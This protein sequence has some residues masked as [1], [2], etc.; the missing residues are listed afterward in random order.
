MSDMES[1]CEDEWGGSLID[2]SGCDASPSHSPITQTPSTC[3][4]ASDRSS[5]L[6]HMDT[7]PLAHVHAA[8]E[9][10]FQLQR[11]VERLEKLVAQLSAS[12]YFDDDDVTSVTRELEVVRDKLE[13]VRASVRHLDGVFMLV[14]LKHREAALESAVQ[15]Q[16]LDAEHDKSLFYTLVRKQVYLTRLATDR[17]AKESV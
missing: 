17:C 11:K 9:H 5:T 8:A 6:Q 2:F 7:D 13:R 12:P 10:L 1:V 4:T 3:S 15:Q 16:V 14:T